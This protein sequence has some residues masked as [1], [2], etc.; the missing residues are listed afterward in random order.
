MTSR[1][2]NICILLVSTLCLSLTAMAQETGKPL[3]EKMKQGTITINASVKGCGEDVKQHCPGLGKN[4]G[5]IF[6]CL[7]AYEAQ[8]TPQCKQGILE[9]TLAMK[10]GIAAVEYSISACEADADKH[11]LDVQPGEGR[12]L[13]CIKANESQVSQQCITALKDTGLWERLP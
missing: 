12:L 13:T 10:T 9:A 5:K 2:T 1:F 6:M 7:S 3:A 4:S 11:C 8:L